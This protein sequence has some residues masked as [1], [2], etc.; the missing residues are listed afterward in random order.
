MLFSKR[1]SRLRSK[2]ETNRVVR[3]LRIYFIIII[4]RHWFTIF[5]KLKNVWTSEY[6]RTCNVRIML[7][8]GAFTKPLLPWRNSKHYLSLC[9]CVCERAREY[10]WT[11]ACVCVHVAFIIQHAT[12]M[13]HVAM[14]FVATL[15]QPYF[16]TLSH[17]RCDF[18]KQ[19]IEYKMC[20]FN[21]STTF[22]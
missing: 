16:S 15:A 10:V 3:Q 4:R 14:W 7:N 9:V 2:H 6:N 17:K 20:V 1:Q 13:R 21:F 22:V 19:V 18:R 8:W 11:A 5:W 12:R